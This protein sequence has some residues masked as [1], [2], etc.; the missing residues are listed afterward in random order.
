MDI[1]KSHPGGATEPLD[2]REKSS[3]DRKVPLFNGSSS[4]HAHGPPAAQRVDVLSV[5]NE[6]KFPLIAEPRR[7][8]SVCKA[9]LP[10][11]KD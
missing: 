10:Y 9:L 4:R 7:G 8:A 5:E 1:H 3:F 2:N 11:R 6:G